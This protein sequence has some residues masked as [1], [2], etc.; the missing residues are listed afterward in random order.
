MA[1]RALDLGQCI[2]Y[3]GLW[4]MGL[5]TVKFFQNNKNAQ[6]GGIC[7]KKGS[8]ISVLCNTGHSYKYTVR[9]N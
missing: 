7:A 5:R 9:N 8:K 3:Y 4:V 6:F 1:T 2:M